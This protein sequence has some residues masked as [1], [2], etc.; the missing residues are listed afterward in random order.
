MATYRKRRGKWRTEVRMQGVYDSE[1]FVSLQAAKAWATRRESEIMGGQRGEIPNLTL[2]ELFGRYKREVSRDKKGRRWEEI[3]LDA[4]G[5]DRLA[6]VKLR[7]LDAP[8]LSD[9]QQRR[10]QAVKSASVRRER[11]LLNNVFNVA[12]NEW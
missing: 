3:R 4:L 8:H 10:L 1:T 6:Q 9:W 2:G 12:V 11:N 5:R 7:A